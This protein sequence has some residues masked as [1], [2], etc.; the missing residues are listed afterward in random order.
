MHQSIEKKKDQFMGSLTGL[1]RVA[2]RGSLRRLHYGRY[3]SN[4]KA[5]ISEGME[6]YLWQNILFKDYYGQVKR[7]TDQLKKASLKPFREQGQGATHRYMVA[8]E[9]RPTLVA[10]LTTARTTL[11]QINQLEAKAA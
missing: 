7:I 5:V 1:D 6:Q 4:L 11:N 2:L 3:D 8:S 10:V 9:A